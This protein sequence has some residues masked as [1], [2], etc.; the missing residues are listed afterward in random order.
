V[1]G[2]TLKSFLAK[3]PEKRGR[4]FLREDTARAFLIQLGMWVMRMEEGR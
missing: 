2:G 3:Q 1:L 4:K